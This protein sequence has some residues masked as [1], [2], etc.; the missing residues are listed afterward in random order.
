MRLD[1]PASQSII[2][3]KVRHSFNPIDAGFPVLN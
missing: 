3:V 2:H 1:L